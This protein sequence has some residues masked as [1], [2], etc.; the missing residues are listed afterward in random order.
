MF[1]FLIYANAEKILVVALTLFTFILLCLLD[2]RECIQFCAAIYSATSD[3]DV[4]LI[5]MLP[6]NLNRKVLLQ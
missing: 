1:N 4:F 5:S 6:L 2:P 3:A